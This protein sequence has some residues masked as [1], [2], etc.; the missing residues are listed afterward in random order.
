MDATFARTRAVAFVELERRGPIATS[1]DLRDL[2][3]AL[4]RR[5][6]ASRFAPTKLARVERLLGSPL[7][8][9]MAERSIEDLGRACM[10]L[11][12]GL[13]VA[14]RQSRNAKTIAYAMQIFDRL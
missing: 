14:M 6:S 7:P 5:P 13:A 10:G 1:T 8:A 12:G 2:M 3:Q 4:M 11:W 9:W